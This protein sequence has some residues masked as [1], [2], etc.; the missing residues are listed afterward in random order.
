MARLKN[1]REMSVFKSWLVAN[2]EVVFIIFTA[3]FLAGVGLYTWNHYNATGD[4]VYINMAI[5]IVIPTVLLSIL[6][7]S[8]IKSG[9]CRNIY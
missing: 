4:D 2:V 7:V 5:Y 8:L 1:R 9:I 3:L 6:L